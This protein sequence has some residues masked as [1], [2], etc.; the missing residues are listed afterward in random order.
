MDLKRI[1][2]SLK[3]KSSLHDIEF[4]KIDALVPLGFKN[5]L[6][7]QST[8]YIGIYRGRSKENYNLK[9]SN[10]GVFVYV[11]NGAFD[12][13]GRLLESRDGLS[14]WDTR[15]IEFEALSDNAI[16][17]LFEIDLNSKHI[18]NN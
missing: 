12:V 15:E 8:G 6:E 17:L 4:E 1:T 11:I 5:F 3:R 7:A 13:H 10:N 14:L 9:N 18:N 2:L 16:I